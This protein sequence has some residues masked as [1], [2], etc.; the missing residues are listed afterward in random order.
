[1]DEI[2]SGKDRKKAIWAI[3]FSPNL[4]F[5]AVGSEDAFIDLYDCVNDYDWLGALQ[6]HT[7]SPP[8]PAT[9]LSP[10]PYALESRP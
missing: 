10:T 2:A 6:G 3:K 5:M 4:R 1:M 9:G 7:G 8:A